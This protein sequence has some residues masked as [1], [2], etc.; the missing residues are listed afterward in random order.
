MTE[1]YKN[2]DFQTLPEPARV[3]ISLVIKKM[4]YRKKVR[5]D[6][7]AELVA[8][9]ADE[10]KDCKTAEERNQTA[11]N[12]IEAFGNPKLL[13]HLLRRAKKRCRPLWQK[14]VIRIAQAAIVIV[15]YLVICSSRLLIGTPTIRVNYVDWL[16]DAVRSDTNEAL[17]A[18]PYFYKA[19]ALARDWPEVLKKSMPL[20][21]W[22]GDMSEQQREAVANVLKHNADALEILRQGV[23]K[24]YYWVKYEGKSELLQGP[25][26]KAPY[27]LQGRIWEDIFRTLA[28]YKKIARTL[29]LQ[30]AAEAYNGNVNAAL[31]DCM[32]MQKFASHLQGKGLLAEQ[33]VGTAIEALTHHLILM[34]LEKTT[35]PADVLKNT[36]KGLEK[37][38]ATAPAIIGLDAEK[39]F[40]YDFIQRSFTDDGKGNGRVL[41]NGIPLVAGD[42][43]TGIIRFLFWHFPDRKQVKANIDAYF[44][45]AQTYF[46]KTPW[47]RHQEQYESQKLK[48]IAKE[49]FFFKL[50]YPA[51]Q[52][53]AELTWRIKTSRVALI[54]LLAVLRYEKEQ[55]R[56]PKSLNELLA[57]QYLK[58]LP[59][60]PYSPRS[61]IPQAASPGPIQ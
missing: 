12:L 1:Q 44:R 58:Q 17:N 50:S 31:S 2:Y 57:R 34:V 9:F 45:Q 19:V 7:M 10:L 13:A 14:A 43:K 5:K 32:V 49:S 35:V 39:A 3:F 11:E 15:L 18:R 41:K 26:N 56:Y 8:H 60:D 24:P 20:G 36:Q 38:Y 25:L 30:I 51:W 29:A 61:P 59:L 48:K 21:Y 33:L 47:Q 54:T 28:G 22:P 37:Q 27:L 53:A 16:N 52:R 42:W 46:Q 4:R 55:G 40:W 23:E 6:V